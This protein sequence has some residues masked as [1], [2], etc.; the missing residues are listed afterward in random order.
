M[1]G[2]GSGTGD[3]GT[4]AIV[5]ASLHVVVLAFAIFGLP[6]F[7][8]PLVEQPAEVEIIDAS[9]IGKHSAAPKVAPPTPQDKALPQKDEPTPP[10]PM[11]SPD[12]AA[13][14]PPPTPPKPQLADA[15]PPPP[16]PPPPPTIPKVETPKPPEP[17]KVPDPPKV[18]DAEPLKPK[19]PEPPKPEPKPPE[20]P[21]PQPK[22]PEPPKPKPP[23]PPKPPAPPKPPPPAPKPKAQSLDDILADA[24][25]TPAPPTPNIDRR[26]A[27]VGRSDPQ[28]KPNPQP[29]A[30]GPQ[31]ASVNAPKLTQ[32]EEWAVVQK[33]RPCWNPPLG[34]KDA[35]KLAIEIAGS[36]GRDGRVLE[37]KIVDESRMR[38]SFYAAAANAALR[39]TLNPRCQPWPLPPEK[40]ET[41]KTFRFT[42]DPRF[43]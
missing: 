28:A 43:F 18:A 16:P 1:N 14:P 38:D 12:P 37:A 26:N 32:S 2:R 8:K 3:I 35:D 15:L 13:A 9:E 7:T 40:Y 5:S 36:I 22:P 24:S 31:T 27:P 29:P 11:K 25:K 34:A 19:P 41:W 4:P 21:P 33:I 23:E 17:P 20:P 6:S 30:R 42:F 39:A 10:M